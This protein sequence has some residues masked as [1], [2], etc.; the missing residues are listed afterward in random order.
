MGKQSYRW[1]GHDQTGQKISGVEMAISPEF[2]R[3]ALRRKRIRATHITRQRMAPAWLNFKQPIQQREIA[4]LTR[5]LATLLR[6]GIPLLQ[7]FDTMDRSTPPS[8]VKDLLRD[9]FTQLEQGLPLHQ[10]LRSHSA[11]GALYCN[12]V[13]AGEMAGMLDTLL[14]RLAQHLEKTENLRA[15]LRAA[16]I[17]PCAIL[18]VACLVLIM[19]LLYVVPAFQQ[20]FLSFG[21]DLPWL[22]R[23]V[24]RLSEGV[25]HHGLLGVA[26]VFVSVWGLKKMLQVNSRWQQEWHSLLL[27]IPVAGPLLRH[28]CTARW[29]RT[30]AT[31]FSAGIPLTEALTAVAGVTGNARF[32]TATLSMHG[33]LLRGQSLSQALSSSQGLF[34]PMVVQMCAIGEESGALDKMLDKT[35]THYEH[36]VEATVTQL[37]TLLEPIIMVVLGLL[38]GGLVLALYLPIF[39]MGQVI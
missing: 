35:A 29:S 15:S 36:E 31:L 24:L 19:I 5:Q 4:R 7:S 11:F 26:M 28:A 12:L 25:Q 21:A 30:L 9:V 34:P 22:T 6:A 32:E 27:Q 10:A 1:V 2:V 18:T 8:A 20:I 39:Q 37:T 13:M 23:F 33:Q 3:D 14:E 16:L 38:I 17:Y